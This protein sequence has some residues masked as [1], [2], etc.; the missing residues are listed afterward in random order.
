MC[1]GFILPVS[2]YE[3]QLWGRI[4]DSSIS[5]NHFPLKTTVSEHCLWSSLHLKVLQKG[6]TQRRLCLSASWQDCSSCLLPAL[7]RAAAFSV[8]HCWSHQPY[9][10][11]MLKESYASVNCQNHTQSDRM[12]PLCQKKGNR[13]VSHRLSPP[14]TCGTC[15]MDYLRRN[16]FIFSP[17]FFSFVSSSL[18]PPLSLSNSNFL[19]TWSLPNFT[20]PQPHPTVFFCF[21]NWGQ[22]FA[23]F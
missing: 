8:D 3:Y 11:S 4:Q 19:C 18:P 9:L 20:T 16:V 17:L 12:L 15:H 23:E 13:S 7:E 1:D 2:V 22:K 14:P 21:K 10:T 6:T 5:C